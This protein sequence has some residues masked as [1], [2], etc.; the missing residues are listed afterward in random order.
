MFIPRPR[1][2]SARLANGS[3][4]P[5]KMSSRQSTQRNLVCWLTLP[6]GNLWV[7][8]PPATTSCRETVATAGHPG[9][10]DADPEHVR[11]GRG[12]HLPRAPVSLPQLR[13]TTPVPRPLDGP[14]G[15]SARRGGGSAPPLTRTDGAYPRSRCSGDGSTRG[16]SWSERRDRPPAATR[17]C[18]HRVRR[19]TPAARPSSRSAPAARRTP[20]APRSTARSGMGCGPRGAEPVRRPRCDTGRHPDRRRNSSADERVRRGFHTLRCGV[21]DQSIRFSPCQPAP[22][23][24]ESNSRAFA[25]CSATRSWPWRAPT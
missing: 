10:S 25:R 15:A 20:G 23:N 5:P 2:E 11:C 3:T 18:Q 22:A 1:V 17:G 14:V 9:P 7:A 24:L 21:N 4:P 6:I 19:R 13:V 12:D 16:T 8:S